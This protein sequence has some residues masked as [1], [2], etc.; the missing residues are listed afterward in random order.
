MLDMEEFEKDSIRIKTLG[1]ELEAEPSSA[2]EDRSKKLA[3]RP[4]VVIVRDRPDI[5]DS[6]VEELDSLLNVKAE[7]SK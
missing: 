2:Q 3:K 4:V 5:E 6:L 1:E 7:C